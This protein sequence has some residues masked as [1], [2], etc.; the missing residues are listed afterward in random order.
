VQVDELVNDLMARYREKQQ[1]SLDSVEQRWR[2]HLSPHFSKRRASDVTTATVRRYVQLR[3]AEEKGNS[4]ASINRELAI[5][6]AAFNLAL[7]STPP[8]IRM[9]PFI[10]TLKNVRTGFLADADQAKLAREYAAKGLWLRA[11]FAIGCSFGWR[12]GEVL[13]W[14]VGQVDLADRTVRLEVGST[15]NG[16]GRLVSLTE[17]C[18]MLLQACCAGKKAT[19][20]VLT[21]ERNKPVKDFRG[22]WQHACARAG[23]AKFI[24]GKCQHEQ[25]TKARCK[26][27]NR[28]R[29]RY[30]GLLFHDLRRT[31]ARN[32]RRLGVAESV[33]MK[34]TGHK[35]ASVFRRYD[36]I[37]QADLAA[38]ARCSIKK[39]KSP[40]G[41]SRETL[42]QSSAR[43]AP[44]TMRWPVPGRRPLSCLTRANS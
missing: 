3:Q 11:A 22:A 2:L 43:V 21:R 34:I 38:A 24:C 25:T 20:H 29:W 35:T 39:P 16:R 14:R 27:G 12:Y 42:C 6:K 31:A 10:P 36:I 26:C 37:E 19:D 13:G 7:E 33:A 4:P 41:L 32:L 23:L 17:E 8:K 44:N 30:S 40:M 15:K 28:F 9:V 18:F 5:L 1:R